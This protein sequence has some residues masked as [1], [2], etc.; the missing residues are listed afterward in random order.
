MTPLTSV[1]AR[2]DVQ[3]DAPIDVRTGTRSGTRPDA[4][5]ILLEASSLLLHTRSEEELL[6][7]T[8]DL[9]SELLVADAYGVWRESEDG[10]NWR[11]VAGRG[12]SG[13]YALLAPIR[14]RMPTEVW[15]LEDVATDQRGLMSPAEY[16]AEGIRSAL[17]VPWMLGLASGAEAGGGTR[18][19]VHGA[20]VY[21]WRRR[22]RFSQDDVDYA[23]AL[24]NLSASAIH[25]LELNEQN[26]REQQ[27]LAF[28]AEASE[29]LASSLDYQSTL[30]RVAQLAVGQIAEWCAVHV[31]EDGAR[32]GAATRVAMAHADPAMAGL[33]EEYGRRYP[34]RIDPEH[35]LGRVLRTGEPEVVS[36]ITDAMLAAA[37]PDGEHL[38]MLRQFRLSCSVVVPLV[39]RGEVLGAIRLMGTDG[40]YFTASDV[41]LAI[42]LG[43]RAAAAIENARLHKALV[44]QDAELRL[45]HAAAR[46]GSWSWDVERDKLF[47]SEEFKALHGLAP[48]TEPDS[49]LSYA[50]VHPED[51]ERSRREFWETVESD[52]MVFSSEHRAMTPDGRVLWLQVRGRI[53]RNAGGKATWIAGLIIDVTETRLAEQ[54]LRRAEKLA[55]AGRLAATVAHEVNN[56]LEALVNLVYLAQRAEGLPE[57]AAETLKVAEGELSRMAHI[58]RQTLG[59][60][61]ES[62]LPKATEMRK[63]AAQVTELYR[64]RGASR[65]VALRGPEGMGEEIVATVIAGEMKQVVANLIANAIDATPSGGAVEVRVAREEDAVEIA[66]SDTGSGISEANRKHLFEPFFTT[67]ADVGTGLGLWVSKGIVEKHGGTITVDDAGGAGTTVRVR[68]PVG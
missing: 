38:R 1:Q 10:L 20:I 16:E 5:R 29:T 28:L 36:P 7:Q 52:A 3:P 33:A 11:R 43:R 2:T 6:S 68:V 25:R 21:Y 26:L 57:E 47:W 46:M 51:R 44:E 35:G 23:R 63:L 18:A 13:G 4:L 14:D 8:L 34:E 60:Y 31:V 32:D 49:E 17:V 67:K 27:R 48:E 64:S 65:G 58:V 42:D 12:L 24:S 39:S 53:R 55:A 9:A 19:Q 30:E 50:L 54:A 45:S 22:R 15:K 56:P 41:K 59:F 66:V 62:T 40:H 37:V 61:R